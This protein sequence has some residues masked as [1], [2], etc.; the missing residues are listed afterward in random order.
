[1]K[2][3]RRERQHRQISA[4]CVAKRGPTEP[5]ELLAA[6]AT[7]A[8]SSRTSGG[9]RVSA[10][11]CCSDFFSG[12]LSSS[13]RIC[14][15][16]PGPPWLLVSSNVIPAGS[17]LTFRTPRWSIASP[18]RLSVLCRRLGGSS[19]SP[20]LRC[21]VVELAWRTHHPQPAFPIVP[22]PHLPAPAG[23]PRGPVHLL[24]G[25][26]SVCSQSLMA[27]PRGSPGRGAAGCS[28]DAVH[29]VRGGWGSELNPKY[30]S[31]PTVSRFTLSSLRLAPP[32]CR[33]GLPGPD[34]GGGCERRVDVQSLRASKRG[35]HASVR[36]KIPR[37]CASG[38]SAGHH[39]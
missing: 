6:G 3:C 38:P 27:R 8:R 25:R 7:R 39:A 4:A 18:S 32:L 31:V 5:T 35:P 12:L 28:G 23:M 11:S 24:A 26:A 15:A 14:C 33:P 37:G 20:A 13:P 9:R 29:A 21:P 17:A 16:A 34:V 36:R 22:V 10:C 19:G 2:H 30:S 1:M